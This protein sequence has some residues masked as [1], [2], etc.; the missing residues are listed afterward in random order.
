MKRKLPIRWRLTVWNAGLLLLCL[1]VFGAMLYGGLRYFLFS[2]FDEQVLSQGR[3][4]VATLH[5]ESSPPQLAPTTINDLQDMERFV[6][7]IALDGSAIQDPGASLDAIPADPELMRRALEGDVPIGDGKIDGQTMVYVTLPVTDSTGT[8]VALLQTGISRDDIDDLLNIVLMA[9]LILA[10]A[11]I[12]VAV[13]AGYVVAGRALQPVASITNLAASI[14]DSDL[15]ERLDLDLPDDE[16]GRLAQTFDGMLAR[17]ENAFERQKQF[18]STASHELR[19]PLTLLRSRID[20]ALTRPREEESYRRTLQELDVDVMRLSR[21]VDTLLSLTRADQHGLQL[22]LSLVD[23]DVVIESIHAQ[24]LDAAQKQSVN[25]ELEIEP[26]V[27]YLDADLLIQVLVNLVDNALTHTGTGGTVTLGCHHVSD[28]TQI[29]VWDTGRGIPPEHQERI[30]ERF[31]RVDESRARESG[32][33]GLGLAI[34]KSIVDVH[35]GTIQLTSEPGQGST[36]HISFPD[37]NPDLA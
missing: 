1:L 37:V 32:G 9:L 2:T 19:T 31:Y 6:R 23:V 28:E 7:L 4:A 30:F 27:A 20:L 17:M 26:V 14:S 8:T 36:F 33:A 24:Y 29:W 18:S 13:A 25:L 12:A 21:L 34:V 15:H 10:P 5:P 11:V 22:D 16:L 35:N 3:L